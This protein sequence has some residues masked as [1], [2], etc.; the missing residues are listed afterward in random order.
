LRFRNEKKKS[1]TVKGGGGGG[2]E[3]FEFNISLDFLQRRKSEE[4][5]WSGGRTHSDHINSQG[6]GG[7]FED[8]YTRPGGVVIV[9]LQNFWLKIEGGVRHICIL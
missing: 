3:V 2:S 8:F 4:G 7:V 5:G 6:Q 9:R 1:V